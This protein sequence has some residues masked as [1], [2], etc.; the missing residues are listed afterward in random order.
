MFIIPPD[1][2]RS[3]V[4]RG[5]V[6]GEVV[7]IG[8]VSSARGCIMEVLWKGLMMTTW[9]SHPAH[10]SILV[11]WLSCSS[12]GHG[13]GSGYPHGR[14]GSCQSSSSSTGSDLRC[15]GGYHVQH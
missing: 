2:V 6:G 9:M 3:E 4:S 7:C 8:Q 13:Q 15:G 14:G 12:L 11:S 5:D 10:C 1:N